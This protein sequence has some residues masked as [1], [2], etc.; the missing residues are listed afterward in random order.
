MNK[1]KDY[2]KEIIDEL[3]EESTSGDVGSYNTPFAFKK[4]KKMKENIDPDGKI[5]KWEKAVSTFNKAADKYAKSGDKELEDK[6]RENAK[7]YE[8]K[9]KN[10]NKVNESVIE[11]LIKEELLNEVSYNKFK[12]EVKYRTKSETL[13]KAIREIKRKLDEVDRLMEYTSRMKGELNEDQEGVKY[14]KHGLN[15]VGKISETINKISNKVK[16]IYQ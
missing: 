1:L 13:Y 10:A 12:N 7:Y 9:V 14:W 16:D 15:A 4:K 5:A 11:K 6:A 3:D 8:D 2:I